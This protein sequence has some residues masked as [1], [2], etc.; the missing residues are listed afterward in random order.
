[1]SE[2]RPIDPVPRRRLGAA[3]RVF[4][5]L[6]LGA[7]L[8]S[9][10][11]LL[12][13]GEPRLEWAV[14]H[15]TEP[16]GQIWLRTLMMVVLPLVFASLALGVAGLGD[17]GKLGRIGARTLAY[18]GL[19]TALS[20]AIGLVV[21][22]LLQP[23]ADLPPETRDRLL[24]TYADE[25][26][27]RQ[28]VARGLELGVST[29]VNIVPRNPV[30]AMV[31]FD[32]LAVIFFALMFG[33]GLTRLPPE[34]A[35]PMVRVLQALEGVAGAIIALVMK[36]AP[37]GVFALMA[38]VTARFGFDLLVKLGLYVVT[39][40]LALALQMFGVYPVLVRWLG[41]L[42][43]VDLFRR[44]RTILLTAFSTS[45][46]S[47]TLPTTLEQTESRV[48]VPSEICGFVLPLGATLNMNGTALFEGVTVI[49]LAQVFG[50]ELDLGAQATLLV[51]CVLTAVGAAGTPSSSMPLLVVILESL[52]LP[53]EGIAIILGVDRFLDMCRTTLNVAGDVTAAVVIARSE[54]LPLTPRG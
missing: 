21:V 39:V 51:V 44:S 29:L 35:E 22:N 46:S 13:S 53:G 18:F 31:D 14:A 26:A 41:G 30:K 11:N 3:T 36:L 34:R 4:L 47:A 28:Q 38:T 37:Y 49:F 20:V 25:S 15:L 52:G 43:P 1:M 5:G 7:G 9:L 6:V 42:G 17:L 54:G 12:W 33:I 48:G 50:L 16:V 27:E 2:P 8:G 40:L 32:L 23:G 19:V 24:A 10:A 45:S